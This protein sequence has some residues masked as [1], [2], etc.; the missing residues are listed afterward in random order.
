M[1]TLLRKWHSFSRL[2]RNSRFT[3]PLTWLM[4]GFARLTIIAL[5]FALVRKWLGSEQ[6]AAPWL[7][8]LP[9]ATEAEAHRIGQQVRTAARYTPWTSNC[10]PQALVA[11]TLLIL[12]RQPHTVF[13]GLRH[14]HDQLQAHAWVMSGHVAVTGGHCFEHYTVVGCFVWPMALSTA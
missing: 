9:P 1:K 12:K 14:E 7:H 6:R 4:L 13:F 5:P 2:P 11:R 10:F 8:I 3:L